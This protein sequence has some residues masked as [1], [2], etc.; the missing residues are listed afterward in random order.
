[1]RKSLLISAI[2]LIVASPLFAGGLLTN[3]N[4]HVSF[5]RMVARGATIGIGGA[6]YNPAGT[7]FMSDGIYLSFNG[8][9]A[10]QTRTI[11]S[12]FALGPG[13][14]FSH[15]YKGNASA[16]FLPSFMAAYKKGNLAFSGSFGV[17]GGGGKASFNDGLPMFNNLVNVALASQKISPKAYSINSALDGSQIIWGLQIG[18]A[19]RFNDWLSGYAGGRMN[20]FVGSY[21]GFLNAS[22]LGKN[23][24]EIVGMDLDCT[25][26]GWGLTPV[27]GLDAKL[28]KFNIGIKYEFITKMN[29][30]NRTKKSEFRIKGVPQEENSPLVAYKDGVN[31]PSDIPAL[32]SGAV[33]YNILPSLRA[34]VEGHYFFDK[35]A[36][37][38][39]DKQKALDRGTIEFLAGI[40]WDVTNRFTVSAGFQNTDYG[41][42]DDFQSDTSFAC[43]S[44]SIG[45]GAEIK[46]SKHLDMNIGYFW[47]NYKDYKMKASVAKN[48]FSENTY[49]RTNKVFGLGIDYKF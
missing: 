16:P 32:L 14:D 26:S 33:Q 21:E 22:L 15:Y 9:S 28:G 12:K 40:E 41:Q 18:A 11:D 48:V 43:D 2:S 25:Q 38:A 7:A 10:Y 27:L 20:Y 19:Y 46:L 35:Q 8:Q 3:T 42:T 23:P 37:M 31:T 49:D 17:I 36:G 1:M 44:Y 4:Q 45:F 34:S 29:I 24:M 5:L 6:Y 39:Q 30:E 47:T 13:L